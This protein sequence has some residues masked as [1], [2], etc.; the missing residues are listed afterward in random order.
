MLQIQNDCHDLINYIKGTEEVNNEHRD[1]V[2]NQVIDFL[3]VNGQ[4]GSPMHQLARD[5]GDLFPRAR[6]EAAFLKKITEGESFLKNL[7]HDVQTKKDI[8]GTEE[9]KNRE[10]IKTLCHQI[11]L[12][13]GLVDASHTNRLMETYGHDKRELGKKAVRL[14]E[15]VT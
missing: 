8:E 13:K 11:R 1:I 15:L 2:A 4:Q 14:R 7:A 10:E 6:Q 9:G 12:A 3:E 5:I